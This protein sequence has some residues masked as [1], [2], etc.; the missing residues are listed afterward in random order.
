MTI[1]KSKYNL[2]LNIKTEGTHFKTP[3]INADD[4]LICL[5][6]IEPQGEEIHRRKL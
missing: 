1:Y 2:L 6:L 4:E 5:L 3:K